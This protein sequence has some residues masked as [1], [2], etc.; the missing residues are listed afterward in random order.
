MKMNSENLKFATMILTEKYIKVQKER[1]YV[2]SNSRDYTDFLVDIYKGNHK[3]YKYILF[4]AL[5][6]KTAFKESIDALSLQ[7]G[8]GLEVE[9]MMLGRW[10]TKSQYPSKENT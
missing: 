1:T 7:E 10:G 5:L 4:T 6:A 2:Q 8:E 9:L 3:T